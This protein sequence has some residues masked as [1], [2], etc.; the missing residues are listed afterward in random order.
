MDEFEIRLECLKMA[1]DRQLKPAEVV[2]DASTYY[3]FL[4]GASASDP[5]AGEID[6]ADALRVGV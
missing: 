5:S 3:A 6:R 2:V 4:T 1:H